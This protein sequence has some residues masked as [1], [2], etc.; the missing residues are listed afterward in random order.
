MAVRTAQLQ[1][2]EA[3]Y[4]QRCQGLLD[5]LQE[6]G[7]SGCALFDR[8]YVLYYTG[9][10]FIPTERPIVFAMNNAGEQALYVPHLEVEHAQAN[11][12]VD[13]VDH[14]REYP[15]D[16]HPIHG[17]AAM[18]ADVITLPAKTGSFSGHARASAPRYA[19]KARSRPERRFSLRCGPGFTQRP[20]RCNR[21]PEVVKEPHRRALRL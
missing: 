17:L 13:R 21:Q 3:E 11:A 9:F 1:I 19:L 6:E 14:Y 7:L 2:T 4:R 5:R 8:D 15:G 10:A 16:P 20:S 12:L 18:L